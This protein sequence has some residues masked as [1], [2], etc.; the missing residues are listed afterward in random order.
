MSR[1]GATI[2]TGSSGLQVQLSVNGS[3][4]TIARVGHTQ[5]GA[6]MAVAAKVDPR[7]RASKSAGRWV[8]WILKNPA[9]VDEWLAS[10]G[11]LEAVQAIDVRPW[12]GGGRPAG[13]TQAHAAA[14]R[15][16]AGM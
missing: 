5:V 4:T 2:A 7:L 3:L 8:Q 16:R 13:R 6:L 12:A 10:L 11:G 15:W 1:A 14:G 9:H